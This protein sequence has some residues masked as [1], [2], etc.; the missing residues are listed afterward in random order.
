[1]HYINRTTLTQLQTKRYNIIKKYEKEIVDGKNTNCCLYWF[2][3][4]IKYD[5]KN[6]RYICKKCKRLFHIDELDIRNDDI[7]YD[8]RE[9]NYIK[10]FVLDGICEECYNKKYENR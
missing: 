5:K 4:E 10:Y 6:Y 7:L 2:C 3:G 8:R 1:M 9:H